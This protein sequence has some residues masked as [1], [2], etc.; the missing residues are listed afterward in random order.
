MRLIDHHCHSVVREDLTDAAFAS[1]LTESDRPPAPGTS[2]WDSALGLAV[3]RWCAPV[4]DLDPYAPAAD[5][6]ARRRALGASE[7]T[8]R[9]LGAAGLDACFVDTGLD[10]AAGAALMPLP[11]L[12]AASGAEV[13]EVVRLERVAE[14]ASRGSEPETWAGVMLAALTDAVRTSRAVALK[15]VVA[16]RYG[17]DIDPARP[18]PAEVANAAGEY[19]AASSTRL[20]HPVLLRHLLWTAV[21]L[22]LPIQLHTGFGDPDLTLHRA[23][24][25]RL[26]DFVRACEPHGVPLVLLHC[27][28][29]HRQAAWLA[30]AFPQ[31]YCDIGLT[32]SYTGPGARRVLA[33]TLELAPFDKVLFST[34]AYGLPELH[35]VGAAAFRDAVDA[36]TADLRATGCPAKDT[37]RIAALLGADNAARLYRLGPGPHRTDAHF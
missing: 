7:S 1:L 37:D 33:E 12:A 2:P 4:L 24:P 19:L 35:L 29:Y 28:P 13:R 26:T 22:G 27:W 14:R 8:R 16:Y 15:S 23:D 34:D 30:Q 3:R 18:G 5:Y 25:S 32:L 20:D 36:W 9:L 17:L 21:D 11:D 31:V 6:L 10:S